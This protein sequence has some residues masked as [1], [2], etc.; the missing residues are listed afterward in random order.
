MERTI[1]AKLG[2]GMDSC[3]RVLNLFRRKGLNPTS[4][5]MEEDVIVI[6][7]ADEKWSNMVA[8]LKTLADVFV[9]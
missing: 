2:T 1:R 5:S 7:V 4:F 6:S 3:V 9:L 8:N